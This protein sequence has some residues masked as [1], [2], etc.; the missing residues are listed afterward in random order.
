M[1]TTITT[2]KEQWLRG[3]LVAV[4]LFHTIATL[5]HATTH[6]QVPVPLTAAQIALV[7]VGL[8]VLPLLGAGLLWTTR[9][10]EAAWLIT[11]PMLVSLLFGFISHFVITGSSDYVLAVPAG[12]WRYSFV[13]S[14][15]V[16]VVADTLGVAI[17][18]MAVLA[19]RRPA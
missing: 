7:V 10:R 13:L 3:A 9:K 8:L 2:I 4:V 17:G 5:W 16:L 19:W 12:V 15:V 6:A 18:V 1:P 14:A 11:V